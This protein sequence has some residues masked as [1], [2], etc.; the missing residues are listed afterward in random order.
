MTPDPDLAGPPE[1]Q[2]DEEPAAE[3]IGALFAAAAYELTGWEFIIE[4]GSDDA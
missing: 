4:R 2:P 3:D 1:Y